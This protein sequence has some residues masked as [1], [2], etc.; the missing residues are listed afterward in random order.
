MLLLPPEV[1]RGSVALDDSPPLRLLLL[2]G[3]KNEDT[4]TLL[5]LLL[6]ASRR[7]QF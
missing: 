4:G 5:L 6:P 7:L 1:A 2:A 3:P